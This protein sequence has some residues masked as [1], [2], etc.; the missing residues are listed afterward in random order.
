MTE[1][2]ESILDWNPWIEKDKV[3]AELLG[4]QRDIDIIQYLDFK[5]IKILQ[6]ARRTGKSTLIYRVIAE[7]LKKNKNV[8]YLNFDD[9]ILKQYSLQ[10]IIE[11]IKEK[12]EVDYLF[13]DEIQ[14]CQNWTVFIRKS[15]DTK[16]FK[17][18]WLTGSNSSLI[19]KEYATLLTGRNLTLNIQ[20]LNFKEY[21]RFKWLNIED[22]N[23]I[24]TTKRIEMKKQ[25]QLYLD[26][27]AFPEVALRK[28]NQKELLINYF[29]DFIYKDIVGRYN[30]NGEKVKNLA[31]YLLSNNSKLFSYRKI[32]VALDL[33]MK[34][35]SDYL[36]YFYE[37][38]LFAELQKF[39]YSFKKQ[40]IWAKK[41]YSLDTWFVNLGFSFSENI[42]RNLENLVFI[43][44]K[45]RKK[46]IFYHKEQSECDFVISN[47]WKI[48]EAIQVTYSLKDLDTKKREVAWLVEAMQIYQLKEGIILTDE[49]EDE[50]I[51]KNKNR[52]F[53]IK[54]IPIWQ[55]LML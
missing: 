40:L 31:M 41:I 10:E 1:I 14:N 39:D 55:W 18:I 38:Y 20:T 8:L 13:L 53:Q 52:S 9:E 33:N 35:L 16:Q 34:S 2:Y 37:V 17:Q 48:T 50:F 23:F 49:E 28:Y 32:A 44:L 43:E 24:S 29:D 22:V 4:Y 7:V 47:W 27:G 11:K 15:Y 54:V 12:R 30:V 19:K 51:E 5:E 26:Y 21:L 36:N 42:G 25:Y 46:E 6:G 3:P 45:R